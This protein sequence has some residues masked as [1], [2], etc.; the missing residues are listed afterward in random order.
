MRE[1]VF[2]ESQKFSQWWLWLLLLSL[3]ALLFYTAPANLGALIL[4]VVSLLFLVMRLVTQVD[5][6]GIRYRFF[7]FIKRR[8]Q[9][10]EIASAK[11]VDYGF[12]GGWGIRLF[13]SYGT[14][15]NVKGSKGLAV[16]LKD[17][18]KFCL[19]TQ[20]PEELQNILSSILSKPSKNGN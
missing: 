2:K 15:Y 4:L 18:K 1:S 12:V 9:W 7:P 19:G 13:T 16:E 5:K 6:E 11:V 17:G 10:H 8:Y 14:I 3:G 20:K